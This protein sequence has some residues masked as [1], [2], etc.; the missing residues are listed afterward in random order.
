MKK[1]STASA[2]RKK[3]G[4]PF[5]RLIKYNKSG[6][7][8]AMNVVHLME[9]D[10]RPSQTLFHSHDYYELVIVLRGAGMHII[11]EQQ[12]PI[13]PGRIFLLFPN[14]K[15]QYQYTEP[16]SLLTFMFDDRI[17][18]PIRSKLAALP[19][20]RKLFCKEFNEPHCDL[21]VAPAIVAEINL[22]LNAIDL[23]SYSDE[24]GGELESM[25]NI[26]KVLLMIIRHE[27]G[28][29]AKSNNTNEINCAVSFMLKNYHQYISLKKLAEMTNSS[30]TTFYRKF[31][32]E[33]QVS[34]ISWLLNLRI[35]KS[36]NLLMCSDMTIGEIA[37]AVGF[38][39]SLYFSRQFKR[40][41]G[42]TPKE[43][44]KNV[45]GPLKIF[46]P[47]PSATGH[48]ERTQKT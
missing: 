11:N 7:V 10:G 45:H 46:P 36:M 34:P 8:S 47:M 24:P 25:L 19:G 17:I 48:T 1:A 2:K 20:Y 29:G 14:E 28:L 32:K 35:R 22:I 21:S 31:M 26:H 4:I 27:Q 40:I 30:T 41:I 23:E 12:L 42:C 33:F 44:R 43:Y 3:N 39:D 18:R 38:S 6:N 37:N 5:L 16:L 15:H 13:H 9:E